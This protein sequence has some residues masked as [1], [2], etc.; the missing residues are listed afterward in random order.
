MRHTLKYFTGICIAA[1]VL[2]AAVSCTD[3]YELPDPGVN[4]EDGGIVFRCADMLEVYKSPD[5]CLTRAG[6]P[7][8]PDEKAIKTLH[9]FFF[10]ADGKLLNSTNYDN[11][12]AYQKVTNASFIKIPTGEG[13]SQLFDEGD[14][15]IHIVAIANIDATD[16]AESATDDANAFYT[17]YST[18][19]KI[20]QNGRTAGGE[21]YLIETYDDL[22]NWVYYPR[23]RMSEDGTYGDISKLPE[24]G[25]PMIGELTGVDLS[26]KPA[27]T[28]VV[29]MKALMAK[30][31]ISVKL[32]PDQFTSQYP[33][34][35]I[36]E[37]GVR[38]MPV[39]VPFT[40]PTGDVKAGQTRRKPTDYGEYFDI[41]DVTSVPMF[42]KGGTP[43]DPTHFVCEDA[44]HEFTT[45]ANVTINKDSEPATFSYY[46]FEN[47]NLPDYSAVRTNGDDA[48]NDNLEPQYP[49]GVA[50]ENYQRW[51]STIA[52]SDRA[53]ALILK[54]EYTTH[55]GLHY[56]AEFT[57]YMG[58]N[59]ET[60]FR[61]ERNHRYDNNITI[62]GLEYIR[63]SDDEAYT[64]DGRVNVYSDN[65]FYL[66]IVN[67]RKVDAHATALP[68]DVWFMLRENGDGSII[69]H[70]D[71][72][73]KIK[74]TVRDHDAVDWIR[75]EKI[76]RATMEASGFKFGTGA[77]DYFTTDLVTNTL[78]ENGTADGKEHG[79]EI[80]VD[81]EEDGSRTR[82]Y[83]YIDE[84]VPT[85]NN[86]TDYG[87]RMATI[88]I[89]YIRSDA[90]GNIVD[91]RVRTLDIEQR[92]LLKV[93]GTW[94]GNG[95]ET[96]N[97]PDT[98]MEYYEEYLDHNDPLDHHESPGELYS[99][100]PWGLSGTNV[101]D[102][103]GQNP[104]VT[105]GR[106]YRVYY[107]AGAWAMMNWIFNRG[108]KPLSDVKL[109]NTSEPPSAFHYCYGKNKRNANGTAAVSGNKGWYMPGIRELEKALVDYYD[110]FSDFRGNLYWSSSAAQEGGVIFSGRP[111]N[112]ARATRVTVSGTNATYDNSASDGDPGYNL[113]TQAN[114]IR[115]FYRVD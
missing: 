13:V 77:R 105:S 37:Y 106:Y 7:K 20:Q 108:V 48:F 78:K 85:S 88:D 94:T 71:W 70:P 89:E 109:F 100:L 2:S 86:P 30:V 56:Q 99:G 45:A 12:K 33:V 91:R 42:H 87:D 34:L 73:T 43:S 76:P 79:W 51:K 25:M 62:H 97:I 22:K 102:F 57:V 64:F 8:N 40:M 10:G 44:D 14:T 107:K 46:T 63:N 65:P 110:T 16:D 5:N 74:F 80:T 11:F 9:V 61:V 24:A 81:G 4:S 82:I 36:T 95:R 15:D 27:A 69:E 66:A 55:Q 96:A 26:H 41:Y 92:A 38:N 31:N 1:G 29:N 3:N 93:S 35:R 39:A 6:G 112:Y 83:F 84:N 111:G 104:D 90:D 28:P 113:R 58:K 21:P 53:S 32:E 17:Q 47:I 68:M 59:S 52:Y 49:A 115:A 18:G 75:M 98:W 103:G 67:E 101:S 23:I 54:G 60:D 114:R 72:D 50:P 19:G